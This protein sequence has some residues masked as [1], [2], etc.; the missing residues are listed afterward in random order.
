MRTNAISTLSL[1]NTPRSAAA[2]MQADLGRANTEVVTGRFA[3][4]GLQLGSRTGVSIALRQTSAELTA[5]S[6]G[7]GTTS[8]RLS[9][10]QSTLKQMQDAADS[11]VATLIGLPPTQRAA[12]LGAMAASQ[13]G[14]LTAL[15]NTTAG[16][17]FV[18]GGTNTKQAPAASYDAVP[19]SAG[20]TA[21]AAAFST[22]FGFTQ[23]DP[24]V[25]TITG[26]QMSAFL[27][28][29]FAALFDS[30]SWSSDWS[31]ASDAGLD[32]RISLSETVPTSASAN[33]PAIRKLAMAYVMGS[34]LGLSNLS[35]EAQA[36]VA[37]KV[38]DVLGQASNGLVT[39]QA[40]LG[41]SQAAI[42]AAG[43]RMTAQKTLLTTQIGT[44]EGVDPAEAKSRIDQLTT[45]LQM[46][47]ALTAQLRQLSLV[48]YL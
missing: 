42:T 6:D 12:T 30:A 3:D 18:F 41:R 19:A 28:G 36:V 11:S 8:L 1:W 4:V 47:Y 10:T 43:T 34:D 22:A 9:T 2:R 40:D 25:A 44:L 21:V 7:N 45:Q 48:S 29:P 17:Q 14:T 39:I 24:R 16:G 13:L 20:K 37:D 33:A 31:R 46:S 38:V 35:A 15:L 23:D 32:S 5:L 27:D 26:D